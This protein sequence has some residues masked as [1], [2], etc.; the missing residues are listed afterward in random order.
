MYVQ[1]YISMREHERGMYKKALNARQCD[2]KYSRFNEKE[3][4]LRSSSDL[5]ALEVATDVLARE[6]DSTLL[7]GSR[8]NDVHGH[9]LA[10]CACGASR[11]RLNCR[12][13]SACAL[14]E[15]SS[16]DAIPHSFG[17]AGSASRYR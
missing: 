5:R 4:M 13:C 1:L 6:S 8:S 2:R 10:S 12:P 3:C 9:G 11:D 17:C 15:G 14:L 16:A 7:L